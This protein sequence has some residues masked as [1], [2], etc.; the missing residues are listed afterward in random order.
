[1]MSIMEQPKQVDI[2]A[3]PAD[4]GACGYLRII[5]PAMAMQENGIN[6]SLTAET[7]FRCSQ[8][9]LGALPP[10][11][12]DVLDAQVAAPVAVFQR[13]LHSGFHRSIPFMQGHGTRVVVEVD[14]NFDC[15]NVNNFAWPASEP[16]W[17][18]AGEI[19]EWIESGQE[20]TVFEQIPRGTMYET[21]E[22][23][24]S[25][26]LNL[27]STISLADAL[28]VTTPGLANHYGHLAKEVHV[29]PNRIP[30]AY[31]KIASLQ[32]ARARKP[33]ELIV[34][35][36]GQI[37]THPN[38]LD[39]LGEA[40]LNCVEGYQF[41]IVGTGHGIEERVQRRPDIITGLV[42]IETYPS[43]YA[44]MDIA[45]CPLEL[46]LFNECKSGLKALEAASLGVVP[47]MSPTAEYLKLYNE[48]VGLIAET[49][50]EWCEHLERLLTDEKFRLKLKGQGLEHARRETIEGNVTEWFA[51]WTGV[52]L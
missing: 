45:L 49:P 27:R 1:M 7:G 9:P 44:H 22:E 39:V 48:G 10:P 26:R 37:R 32:F 16:Y 23:S 4:Q 41:M 29:V 12:V 28:V 31:L 25:H 42:P 24:M 17:M 8:T 50:D 33:Y 51:A 46:S 40:L 13:P 38:D 6:A 18:E 30:A 47:I 3:Y 19:S 5:G 43:A 36:T 2:A 21:V 11:W 14:D 34:G 52:E 20:V 35:W 15:I